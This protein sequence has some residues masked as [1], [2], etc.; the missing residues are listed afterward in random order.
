MPTR[1]IGDLWLKKAE[2]NFHTKPKD[3]GY[4]KPIPEFTGPYVSAEPD[5]YVHE[6]SAND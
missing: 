4:R 2:F 3:Y 5:I 6:L 1:S